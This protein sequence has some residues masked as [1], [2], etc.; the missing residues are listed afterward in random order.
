MFL[1]QCTQAVLPC[2]DIDERKPA[3]I[4][5]HHDLR[6]TSIVQRNEI[7]T[8]NNALEQSTTPTQKAV[9]LSADTKLGQKD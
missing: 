7:N 4:C 5:R 8:V 1:Q 9:T 6:S 3:E 2:A